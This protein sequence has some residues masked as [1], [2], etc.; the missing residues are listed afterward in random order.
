MLTMAHHRGK[1]ILTVG[2]RGQALLYPGIPFIVRTGNTYHL[3]TTI[4]ATG[5][6]RQTAG[7]SLPASNFRGIC[8]PCRRATL[9]MCRH[10]NGEKSA[11]LPMNGIG[12]R[13]CR[14]A[15]LSSSI[16]GRKAPTLVYFLPTE[17]TPLP[18]IRTRAS[19]RMIRL[20][21]I[22]T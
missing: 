3:H 21:I 5:I 10:T 22:G 4:R 7:A 6:V 11:F 18:R 12:R 17:R 2:P 20:T 8:I 16:G 19:T 13:G 9:S 1:D 14:L 15:P